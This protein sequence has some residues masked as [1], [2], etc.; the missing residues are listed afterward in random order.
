M[1]AVVGRVHIS[2]N[3]HTTRAGHGNGSGN[4]DGKNDGDMYHDSREW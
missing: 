1:S 3:M 2:V 4:D